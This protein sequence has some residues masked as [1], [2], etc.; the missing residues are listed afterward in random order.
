MKVCSCRRASKV[1]TSAQP[2]W[3]SIVMACRISLA[4]RRTDVF[5]ICGIHAASEGGLSD[6]AND[7][8]TR[9]TA[10]FTLS[11]SRTY[12][13]MNCFVPFLKATVRF[14]RKPVLLLWLALELSSIAASAGGAVTAEFV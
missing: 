6:V 1:T 13:V 8:L 11:A 7:P 3:I 4:A 14:A 2:Q 5:I 10:T 9:F 12:H